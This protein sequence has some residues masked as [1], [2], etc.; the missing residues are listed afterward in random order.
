MLMYLELSR[1]NGDVGRWEKV[2]KR[3]TLLNKH[4][5]LRGKSCEEE[6][7]QRLFQYGSKDIMEKSFKKRKK[8]KK[9]KKSQKKKI[10]KSKKN[11]RR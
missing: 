11:K 6:D 4:Y 3:L 9:N 5:P 2:L 1:P 7:I 8:S 10:K